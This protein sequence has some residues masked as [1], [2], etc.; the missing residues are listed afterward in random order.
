MSDWRIERSVRDRIL[1][2]PFVK[3]SDVDVVVEDGIATLTGSVETRAEREAAARAALQGGAA[4]VD[5]DLYVEGAPE[6]YGG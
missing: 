1:W 2:S 6:G 4:A 3:L 5:N